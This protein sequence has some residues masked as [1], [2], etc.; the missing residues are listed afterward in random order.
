VADALQAAGGAAGDADLTRVNLARPV[1]D[2]E[3]VHVPRP[4]EV[5]EPVPGP[6]PTAANGAAGPAASGAPVDLNTATLD[7]LDALPGIGPVLA[8]RI[9]DWRAEHGR[10]STVEEL[11]EVSGIGDSVLEQVRPLVRV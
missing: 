4:G 10:F 5:L 8:Q 9:L 3:Q 2:G 11:A 6:G 7:Q 1:V